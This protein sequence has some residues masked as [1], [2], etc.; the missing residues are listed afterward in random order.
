MTIQEDGAA[1]IKSGGVL[2][3]GR[4]ER[5][6]VAV[7][8]YRRDVPVQVGVVGPG[9]ETMVTRGGGVEDGLLEGDVMV[10]DLRLVQRL[11]MLRWRQ[12]VRTR[13][14]L[15]TLRVMAMRR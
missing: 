14:R 9:D 5:A 4:R 2:T 12:T 1:Y 8:Q 3:Q 10:R 7:V 15:G 13:R 11:R 6:V